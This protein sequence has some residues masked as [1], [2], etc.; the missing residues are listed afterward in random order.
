MAANIIK[1]AANGI[2]MEA[3]AGNDI[4]INTVATTSIVEIVAGIKAL[5]G[6]IEQIDLKDPNTSPKIGSSKPEATVSSEVAS[7]LEAVI[8]SN[9]SGVRQFC[10]TEEGNDSIALALAESE[11]LE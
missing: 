9:T 1:V 4:T 10:V 5:A 6:V 11:G 7:K 8:T 3:T 2:T